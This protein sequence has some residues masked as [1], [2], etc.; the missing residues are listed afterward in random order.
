MASFRPWGEFFDTARLS[1]RVDASRAGPNVR[2]WLYNYAAVAVVVA[3]V[4]SSVLGPKLAVLL[5][6]A[7]VGAHAVFHAPSPNNRVQTVASD[8]NDRVSARVDKVAKKI[9]E[10][11]KGF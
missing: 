2:Y 8:L 11:L 3:A 4:T 5:A 7:A 1:S 6:A 9:D 10:K